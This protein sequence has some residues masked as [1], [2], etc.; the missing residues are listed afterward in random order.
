VLDI[1][2]R[3]VL[4]AIGGSMIVLG[5]V[6]M[7]PL[8]L[9]G[10]REATDIAMDIVD[11]DRRRVVPALATPE[12]FLRPSMQMAVATAGGTRSNSLDEGTSEE[13][14]AQL[15]SIRMTVADMENDLRRQR[16][17]QPMPPRRL[18]PTG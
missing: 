14:M 5:L 6:G 3:T 16:V 13:L 18:R 7:V 11:I 15:Y 1:V 8:L 9:R 4:I 10:R 17:H 2:T 12:S